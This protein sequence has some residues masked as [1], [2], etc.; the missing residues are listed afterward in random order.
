[1]CPSRPDYL[2]AYNYPTL[3]A[4]AFDALAFRERATDAIGW[5]LALLYAA[6][7][8][9][10]AY[11]ALGVGRRRVQ[12]VALLATFLS[13]PALLLIERGNIDSIVFAG[14]VAAGI[15]Y[16]WRLRRTAAVLLALMTIAKLFPLGG[17]LLFVS[18]RTRRVSTVALYAALT[19][20]GFFLV[21]PEVGHIAA[22]TPQQPGDSF[23]AAT[24]PLWS[25]HK[26][27]LAVEWS[28]PI[29]R[30]L[31]VLTFLALFCTVA[32]W[33][34]RFP[35][36]RFARAKD[37]L[38]AQ[39]EMDRTAR[40]MFL[41]GTGTFLAAYLP[42]VSFDYRMVFLAPAIVAMSRLTGRNALLLMGTVILLLF[43]S[44][45]VPGYIQAAGDVVLAVLAP[46][47][48]WLALS[49]VRRV[50][51]LKTPSVAS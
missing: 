34:M 12:V 49:V 48:A 5:W 36:G 27:G 13:P 51:H 37:D 28:G 4:V 44:V 7:C 35:S 38:V 18:D 50:A 40:I 33:L 31:G 21:L 39:I 17:S 9:A 29:P 20:L 15:A 46:T 10:L 32:L 30:L 43:V 25:V 26:F 42:G 45:N 23:G 14:V 19:I 1:M 11:V 22:N 3:W 47:L 2:P 41:L 16:V 6:T 24:L 8:A